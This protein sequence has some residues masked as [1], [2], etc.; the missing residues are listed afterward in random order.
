MWFLSIITIT[1]FFKLLYHISL[2]RRVKVHN[3]ITFY[4]VSLRDDLDFVFLQ[5]VVVTS[6]T[7]DQRNRRKTV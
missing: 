5:L 4:A 6:I 1:E 3:P 7:Q 2:L